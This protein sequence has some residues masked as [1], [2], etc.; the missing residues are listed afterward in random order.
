[1]AAGVHFEGISRTLDPDWFDMHRIVSAKA[2]L[3]EVRLDKPV[4]GSG[5]TRVDVVVVDMNDDEGTTGLGF[6][7]A[8]GGGGNVILE[9]VCTQLDNAVRGQEL[10]HPN[11]LWETIATTF[12]R[13][14]WGPNLVA[15]AAIDLAAWD[16]Y[17]KTLKLPLVSALG[18]VARQIPVYGSGG[19]TAAQSALEAAQ[20]AEGYV[21]RGFQAVKP[22]A[23]G[24]IS[25]D[26]EILKAV[27]CAISDSTAVMVDANE[28]CDLPGAKQLLLLAYDHNV[29]FVEEPLPA[30]ALPAYR[31]LA[32]HAPV[33]IATGEHL[34]T[35]TDFLPYLC[36]GLIGVVQPDLAMMGGITPIL[37]LCVL[38]ETFNITVSPHFLPG[39]FVHVAAA[40]RTVRQLEEFPLIESLFEGWPACDAQGRMMPGTENGHGL[41]L[42]SSR[43]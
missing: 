41:R 43:D 42:R 23:Q 25:R 11:A 1:M 13:T 26:S 16:L 14:G 29:A 21:K 32:R 15:L 12:N 37:K 4:G 18:G 34:Q 36:E 40:S 22:R 30:H 17:S 20:V 27:R 19:F 9:C 3:L 8:L 35:A 31:A 7:Y 38:A 33:A 6:T 28:R 5:I 10:V 2:N 39:L 24:N